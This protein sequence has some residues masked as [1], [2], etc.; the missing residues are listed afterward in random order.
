MDDRNIIM[1][2]SIDS[3]IKTNSTLFSGIGAAHLAGETGVI[4]LLRKMGYKLRPIMNISTKKGIKQKESIEAIVKKLPTSMFYNTD[5]LFSYNLFEPMIELNK[6]EGFSFSLATDMANG[7]YYTISRQK[8]Y[9][10][11]YRYKVAD[12]IA[13]MDSLLYEN[14]PGKIT[15][16][17]DIVSNTGIKGI[18]VT[19][20]T[21]QNDIQRCQIYVLENEIIVIKMAGKG[22]YVSSEVG[23]NFFNS[24]KFNSKSGPSKLN[25]S[26]KSKG[27]EVS[28]PSTYDYTNHKKSGQEGLAEELYAFESN[29]NSSYGV[30]HYYY[31]DF[32]YLEEDTFE[33]NRLCNS[34]IKH[35][36]FTSNVTRS[37]TT[38]Q[39][40]PCIKFSSEN[41]DGNRILNAKIIIKGVHYYLAYAI[42]DKTNSTKKSNEFLESFKL[43]DFVHIYKTPVITDHDYAFTVKDET[44]DD[45]V[46][47][48]N[49][50]L[51]GF[52]KEI[53]DAKM[54]KKH[55]TDFA[56][57]SEEKS[58]YSP[59]TGEHVSIYYE[60]YNDYDYRNPETY[61]TDLK[62]Y[63]KTKSQNLAKFELKTENNVQ[64]ADVIF[65][66]TACTSII[67]RKYILKD[68]L[69]FC[70]LATCDS[71][72]GT[73]GWTDD[74]LKTFK[75][76][77]TAIS[78]P[79]FQNSFAQL[80][81][82]LS[83]ADSSVKYAAK[84]SLLSNAWDKSY[85]KTIIEYLNSPEFFALDEESRST[86][87]INAGA[88]MMKK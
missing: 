42:T 33:L 88:L 61:W 66:D 16:R 59:S 81:K 7:A 5:S 2:H 79:I 10:P 6:S 24:I 87:L 56:Y 34:T 35:F 40:L 69:L 83:S 52:Y 57:K 22:K 85:S 55:K 54:I 9:A 73:K 71:I 50:E 11:L 75:H 1:A 84:E 15:S 72:N 43:T 53:E 3:I 82:D 48:V 60:K 76:K 86:I 17:K 67:K 39:Q 23:V 36:D 4:E 30:M 41:K 13:K 49:E 74:F 44:G 58:Y 27:F 68:G 38:Q 14:I 70:L 12:M 37:F 18:D 32:D 8:S 31:N 64:T 26:P 29:E 20:V 21:K 51:K 47:L 77:D 19:S 46:N 63:L 25:F 80:L 45:V 78:K 62:D 65:K 28:I